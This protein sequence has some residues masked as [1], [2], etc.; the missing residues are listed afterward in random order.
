MQGI[1][2]DRFSRVDLFN[3]AS[4]LLIDALALDLHGRGD[5][6]IVVVQ[7]LGEQVE[8]THLL[9]LRHV[10]IGLINLF[11]HQIT[12]GRVLHQAAEV[13]KDQ[14]LLGR[15]L[16]DVVEVDLDQGRD[17]PAPPRS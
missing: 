7:F 3:H 2:T 4:I 6:P 9:H 11:L 5:F 17:K 15:P 14:T 8:L 16:A 13:G 1:R 12:H 10:G